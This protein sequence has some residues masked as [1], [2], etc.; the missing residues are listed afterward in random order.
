MSK[1]VA[2]LA[3]IMPTVHELAVQVDDMI[4]GWD[5]SQAS[6]QVDFALVEA[7]IQAYI[8]FTEAMADIRKNSPGVYM[9]DQSEMQPVMEAIMRQPQYQ[10]QADRCR[11]LIARFE[12]CLKDKGGQV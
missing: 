12:R 7:Y 6:V 8:K 4:E 2:N 11:D 9:E 3:A 5:M 10:A 1:E